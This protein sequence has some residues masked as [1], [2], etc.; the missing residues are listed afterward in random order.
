MVFG[1]DRGN[2]A[3]PYLLYRMYFTNRKRNITTRTASNLQNHKKLEQGTKPHLKMQ[4]GQGSNN[5][6]NQSHLPP[7]KHKVR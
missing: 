6:C 4:R 1:S 2:H 5:Q 3:S 7:S